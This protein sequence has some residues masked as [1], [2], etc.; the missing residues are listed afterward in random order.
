[1]LWFYS[2]FLLFSFTLF[3]SDLV[4]TKFVIYAIFKFIAPIIG[5]LISFSDN[6]FIIINYFNQQQQIQSL[7]RLKCSKFSDSSCSKFKGFAAFLP[8]TEE[9][10]ED[11]GG[12][13]SWLNKNKP[14][15]YKIL[16]CGKL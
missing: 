15:E 16:G 2:L 4:Q 11:F 8:H 14:S 7:F 10:T 3:F 1:M 13:D 9:L 12:L 6:Y 5:P